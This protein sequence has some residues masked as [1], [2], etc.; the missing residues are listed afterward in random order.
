MRCVVYVLW[1]VPEVPVQPSLA[2]R[3]KNPTLQAA[4]DLNLLHAEHNKIFFQKQ[5]FL[6]QAQRTFFSAAGMHNNEQGP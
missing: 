4:A 6:K 2:R 5:T 3:V 1:C